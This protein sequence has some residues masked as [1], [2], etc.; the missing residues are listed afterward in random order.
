MGL[1]GS[2]A[3]SSFIVSGSFPPSFPHFF[4]GRYS[5]LLFGIAAGWCVR[6]GMRAERE[7]AMLLFKGGAQH[8]SSASASGHLPLGQKQ[9]ISL[10]I[11]SR[12]GQAC[13]TRQPRASAPRPKPVRPREFWMEGAQAEPPSL[14]PAKAEKETRMPEPAMRRGDALIEMGFGRLDHSR[15]GTAAARPQ[16]ALSS[17]GPTVIATAR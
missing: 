17:R 11:N 3:T 7:R 6:Q 2:Q 5:A 12:G 16:A 1:A 9:S 10:R 13:R 4:F 8:S 15:T 14:K